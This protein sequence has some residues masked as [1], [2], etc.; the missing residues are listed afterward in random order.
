MQLKDDLQQ[1]AELRYLEGNKQQTRYGLTYLDVSNEEERYDLFR[2][3]KDRMKCKCDVFSGYKQ[4]NK[5]C[6][7]YLECKLQQDSYG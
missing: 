5:L 1:T 6:L 2:R 4:R 3:P 7:V